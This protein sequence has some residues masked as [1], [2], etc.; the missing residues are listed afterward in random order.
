LGIPFEGDKVIAITRFDGAD[1]I[2]TALAAALFL[3]T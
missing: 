2:L 1:S 3:G